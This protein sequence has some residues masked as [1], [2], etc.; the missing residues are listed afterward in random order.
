MPRRALLSILLALGSATTALA[1]APV[2]FDARRIFACTE[3]K[4]PQQADVGRKVVVVSIPISANFS[5]E[6]SSVGRLRFELRMPKSVSVIDF[7]PKTQ[8]TAD[9]LAQN[10]RQFKDSQTEVRVEYGGGLKTEFNAFGARFS[11]GGGGERQ[12][13]DFT[14]VKTDIQIDR[15]PP[16]KQV[17]VAGTDDEG[18]TLYWELPQHSQATRAGLKEYA[19]LAEVAKDWTGDVGALI[20]S[21]KQDGHIV[22]SMGKA[23]GLFLNGDNA[24]R[25]RAEEGVRKAPPVVTGGDA[26]VF[27]NSIDMKLMRIPSGSYLMGALPE[28]AD[29]S[30]DERP[31]HRVR[32]TRPF[33]LGVYEVTQHEYRQ[34]MGHNP[35]KFQDSDQ[36]PV[37]QVSW[38]D[39][40]KFCNKL[41]EREGRKPYYRIE[42]DV[43]SVTGGNGYRLPTEAEW[44]YACRAGSSTRYP[45]GD[46]VAGL[47]DYAWYEKNSGAKTHAVGQKRPNAWGLHDMLGNVWEWCAD[48]YDG[49]YYSSPPP[50]DPPG[51]AGASHRVPRGGSWSDSPWGC[52]PAFRN[53]DEPSYRSFDLGFRV[54]AVQE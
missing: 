2:A 8:T 36:Q 35:S 39:A 29:A 25:G 54:A 38:L 49:N 24:A 45:F 15:L 34:V 14:Q 23:I 26:D 7:L 18:Q 20:C 17:I 41:S 9:A 37:E 16:R 3:V 46:D 53:G 21:A 47:G 28:E 43:V 33:Y 10:E 44:E 22:A 27:V 48:G 19:I 51:A 6:E 1:Q 50:A 4:P 13:R 12:S 30:K 40:V 52:R 11:L 31:Q 42:G 5:A 32:I